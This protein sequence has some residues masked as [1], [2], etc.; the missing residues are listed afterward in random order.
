MGRIT[1]CLLVALMV[2]GSIYAAPCMAAEKVL[3]SFE[4]DTEGWEIPEWALEKQ[5]H[6]A[7]SIE[8]SKDVAKDGKASL[9]LMADFP[10]KLWTGAVVEASEA[11]DLTP[12]DALS[13]DVYL[14]KEAP[15]GLKGKMILTIGENWKFVEMSRSVPLVP[16]QWTTVSASLKPGTTDWAKITVDDNFRKDVK[17]IDIR[18][19]SNKKPEYKGPIYIDNVKVTTK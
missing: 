13:F 19:E 17:K 15:E 2:M 7:R 5:D 12:Y 4:R 6:V 16:G 10:G 3:F 18:V 11:F 1:L 14:P 8:T 9:K